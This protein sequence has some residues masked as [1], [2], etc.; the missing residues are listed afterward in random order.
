M[1][2]AGLYC[3][4]NKIHRALDEDDIFPGL[5]T[6]DHEARQHT[7]ND[8]DISR[9]RDFVRRKANVVRDDSVGDEQCKT[10]TD[11]NEQ[12]KSDKTTS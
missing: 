3:E 2:Y 5:D 12:S 10:Q 11:P 9:F 8:P 4:L 1:D 7:G 6:P